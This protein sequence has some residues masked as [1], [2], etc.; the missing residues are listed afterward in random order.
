MPVSEL[1]HLFPFRVHN[2]L[3]GSTYENMANRR[4]AAKKLLSYVKQ[5]HSVDDMS[6]QQKVGGEWKHDQETFELMHRIAEKDSAKTPAEKTQELTPKKAA[7]RLATASRLASTSD[8][9][10]EDHF[11]AIEA[12]YNAFAEVY[13]YTPSES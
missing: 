11:R 8:E 3:E 10:T 12:A 4:R 7:S 5:G 9:I 2:G 13:E 6:A 1:S